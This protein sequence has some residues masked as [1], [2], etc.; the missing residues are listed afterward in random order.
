[1]MLHRSKAAPWSGHFLGLNR[2]KDW[3]ALV[4][5]DVTRVE[6]LFF[7]PPFKNVRL[8][9]RLGGVEPIGK[10]FLGSVGAG[11]YVLVGKKRVSTLTPIKPGWSARRRLVSVGLVEPTARVARM[12]MQSVKAKVS[13][14]SKVDWNK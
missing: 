1:M 3:L 8:M 4:G 9:E 10:R 6:S 2:I 7:R 12:Q 5:F 14:G 11:A 13:G